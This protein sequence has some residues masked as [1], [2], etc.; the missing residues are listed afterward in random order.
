MAVSKTG[1]EAATGTYSTTGAT[2]PAGTGETAVVVGLNATAGN[3]S[4][5]A[6]TTTK[7]SGNQ[8]IKAAFTT[9][10]IAYVRSPTGLNSATGASDFAHQHTGLTSNRPPTGSEFY[11]LQ[12]RSSGGGLFSATWLNTG[13]LRIRSTGSSNLWTSTVAYVP[14]T[15]LRPSMAVKLDLTTPANSQVRVAVFPVGS[16]TPVTGLDSGWVV[17]APATTGV[18]LDNFIAGR[19]N[20]DPDLT[21]FNIDDF[22]WDNAATD[23]LTVAGGV[24]PTVTASVSPSSADTGVAR[25]LTL[26]IV[27]GTG[28]AVTWGPVTWE[29]TTDAAVTTAAGV[30]SKTFTRTPT[31]A[32]AGKTGTYS[33][34]Q[35]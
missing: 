28:T 12:A 23:L 10:S 30:T 6:D 35:A 19:C 32:G 34:S 1:F 13:F 8:S 16:D 14:S 5:S 7:S 11:L 22:R 15:F 24:T 2:I 26:S 20:A 21:S 3:S 29:G 4:Y 9:A 27:N 17:A 25:T 18:N 33:W 31:V